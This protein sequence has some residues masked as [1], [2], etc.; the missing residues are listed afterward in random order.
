MDEPLITVEPVRLPDPLAPATAARL[1]G[2]EGPDP[3][4]TARR[5]APLAADRDLVLVEGA[6]GLLV[7]FDSAAGT[8]ADL[9]DEL[10]AELLVVTGMGLGTINATALTVEAIRRRGLTPRG[11]VWGS[12]PRE[13]DLAERTNRED[14]ER[15]VGVPVVGGVPEGAALLPPARFAT[16]APGWFTPR[17]LPEG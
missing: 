6:G 7:P 2:T 9:A 1:A 16:E 13:P 8:I 10:G 17:V 14:M 4:D 11:L 3:R 15:W 12:V 5:I